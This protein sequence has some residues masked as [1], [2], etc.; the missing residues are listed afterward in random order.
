MSETIHV[1]AW[2]TSLRQ[3]VRALARGWT[4]EEARCRIRLKVRAEGCPA[5]SIT[6]PM[7]WAAASAGDAYVRIRNIY[8]LVQQGHSFKQAADVAAGK[9]P[10]LTTQRDW[11]GAAAAF[12]IQK[13]EHGTTIKPT[14]SFITI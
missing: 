3:Q 9:A 8:A 11:A 7:P 4:V 12:R 14:T 1:D 2:A 6:L 13:L 5:E 10:K